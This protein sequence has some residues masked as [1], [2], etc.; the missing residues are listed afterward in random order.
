MDDRDAPTEYADQNLKPP[1]KWSPKTTNPGGEV[2]EWYNE[3]SARR[4]Y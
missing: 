4:K 3:L 1:P 2:K